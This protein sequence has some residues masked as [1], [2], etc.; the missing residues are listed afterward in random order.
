MFETFCLSPLIRSDFAV[1]KLK[2]AGFKGGAFLLRQSPKAYNNFFLTVRVQVAS[3]SPLNEQ[4][5]K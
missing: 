1:N 5:N 3:W 2:K 4:T